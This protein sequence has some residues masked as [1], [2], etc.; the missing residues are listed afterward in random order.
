MAYNTKLDGTI[1]RR[2]CIDLSR[3]VNTYVPPD[4]YKM[5]TLKEVLEHT[6]PGHF[7]SIFDIE[8]AYHNIRLHRSSY[9][10]VGFSVLDEGGVKRFY[11]FVILVFGLRTA[12]QVLGR[13]LKPLNSALAKEDIALLVYVD[14]GIVLASSKSKADAHYARRCNFYSKAGLVISAEKSDL[15]GTSATRKTYLG[16]EIDTLDMTLTVPAAKFARVKDFVTEFLLSAHHTA[17]EASSVI[18]QLIAMEPALG[19]SVLFG[20]RLV[21]IEVMAASE[22]LSW[23]RKFVVSSN[24]MGALAFVRDHMDSC[25]GHPLQALHTG[26]TLASV[27]HDKRAFSLDVKIPARP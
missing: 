5:V 27:L 6:L 23:D 16:F 2:L 3:H 4:V 1:K 10:L 18:G 11:A 17:R 14:D 24:A 21:L 7:M 12:A 15:P 22:E 8:K 25:N 20:T 19:P 9:E 13:M 26:F